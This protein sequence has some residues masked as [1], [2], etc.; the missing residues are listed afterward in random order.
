MKSYRYKLISF[1]SNFSIL[2]FSNKLISLVFYLTGGLAFIHTPD[3]AKLFGFLYFNTKAFYKNSIYLKPTFSE[4]YKVK[5]M[6]RIS[7]IETL[8]GYGI[9]Y[10]KSSGCYGTLIKIDLNKHLVLVKLPSGVKKLFPLCAVVTYDKVS[11][12]LKKKIVNTKSGF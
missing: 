11:L 12:K 9:K 2:P 1:I 8:P 5:P 6:S 4:L 3:S 10:V 7:L